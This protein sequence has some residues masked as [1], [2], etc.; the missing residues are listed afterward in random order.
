[1]VQC[2]NKYYIKGSFFQC[3]VPEIHNYFQLYT[4]DSHKH[5]YGN[6]IYDVEVWIKIYK[7][8]IMDVSKNTVD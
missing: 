4:S 2:F 6:N 7:K 5:H 8:K 1:M 3:T